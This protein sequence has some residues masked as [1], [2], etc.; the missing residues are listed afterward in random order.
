MNE[1][2]F[3]EIIPTTKFWSKTEF[4]LFISIPDLYPI[5]RKYPEIERMD[6]VTISY[7]Q[8]KENGK[9]IYFDSQESM[10]DFQLRYL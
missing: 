9:T 8:D 4:W 2:D 7:V 3:L 5:M 10:F 1:N 6:L